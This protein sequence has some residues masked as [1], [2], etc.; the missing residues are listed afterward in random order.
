MTT[1]LL[2]YIIKFYF[3]SIIAYIYKILIYVIILSVG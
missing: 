2:F 1:H 3:I